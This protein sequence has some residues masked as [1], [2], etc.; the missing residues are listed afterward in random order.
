MHC[1]KSGTWSTLAQFIEPEQKQ[2]AESK[3]DQLLKKRKDTNI[4]I[5]DTTELENTDK[6][7]RLPGVSSNGHKYPH[8]AHQHR[9]QKHSHVTKEIKINTRTNQR[10]QHNHGQARQCQN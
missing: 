9:Q 3:L 1:I 2:A 10:F 8:G 7:G 6:T 5:R 4:L